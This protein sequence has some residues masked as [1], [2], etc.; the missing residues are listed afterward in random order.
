MK[1]ILSIILCTSF[2]VSNAQ[3]G[4]MFKK[5]KKDDKKEAAPVAPT[6]TT[7]PTDTIIPPTTTEPT[8]AD[9]PEKKKKGGGGFFQKALLKVAKVASNV[10]GTAAG[11]FTK[12]DDLN[13]VLIGYGYTANLLSKDYGLAASD[14]ISGWKEGYDWVSIFL[15]SR[16]KM[17]FCKLNGTIKVDGNE[18]KHE[19]IGLYTVI[20]P[21]TNKDR[22]LE[23][24]AKSGQKAAYTFTKPANALKLISINN[25]KTNCQ[26][27]ATKDFSI[28]LDNISTDPSAYIEVS[29]SYTI[30]GVKTTTSIGAFKPAK[31]IVFPGYI[32]KHLANDKNVDLKNSTMVVTMFEQKTAID[33]TGTFKEPLMYAVGSQAAQ[34]VKVINQPDLYKSIE[35]KGEDN[36]ALGKIYYNFKKPNAYYSRPQNDIKK[37][38]ITTFA[39]QGKTYYY[40][41]KTNKGFINRGD[42]TTTT[43]SFPINATQIE[44]I[45]NELY[46]KFEAVIKAQY[47]ATILPVE[48]V[49]SNAAFIKMGK[50]TR[51]DDDGETNFSQ[52]YKGLEPKKF[53]LPLAGSF[54]GETTLFNPLGVDAI[55]KVDIKLQ[56]D[57]EK[58]LIVPVMHVEL[59]GKQS[60][61]NFGYGQ[62]TTFYTADITGNGY[63][64]KKKTVITD[65]LVKDIMRADDLL[66]MFTKG[67][68]QICD[69]DK[70]NTEYLTIWNLAK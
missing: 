29:L 15:A 21:P 69:A 68:Q 24:Q 66:Q 37:I 16:D 11:G 64:I 28:Q 23:I 8:T 20:L 13:N 62:P 59:L 14:F 25:S 5:K 57:P 51:A 18:A 52:S 2:L 41:Q 3:L 27:D 65:Q 50:Y 70:A 36:L 9:V 34:Y 17:N 30:I 60:V 45:V 19:A 31:N 10:G 43:I 56:L 49:T 7:T 12:V 63:A 53:A 67:L 39:I 33:E 1:T 35:I 6:T 44:P 47:N 4:G 38:A 22:K 26:I 40:N 46:P 58:F 54:D 61:A 42:K 48:T 32:L 55:L